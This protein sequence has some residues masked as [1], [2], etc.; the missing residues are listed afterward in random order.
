MRIINLSDNA[1]IDCVYYTAGLLIRQLFSLRSIRKCAA[2]YAD[3]RSFS[4]GMT[5]MTMS[6]AR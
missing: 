4:F 6:A 3:G 5:A 1:V 2:A